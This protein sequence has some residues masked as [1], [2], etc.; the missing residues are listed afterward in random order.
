MKRLSIIVAVL[1]LALVASVLTLPQTSNAQAEQQV[2]ELE[3]LI[4]IPE[5]INRLCRV[6]IERSEEPSPEGELYLEF[7]SGGFRQYVTLSLTQGLFG[8]FVAI[9]R[10]D[11]IQEQWQ[12]NVLEQDEIDRWV[13]SANGNG[14]ARDVWHKRLLEDKEAVLK[15]EFLPTDEDSTKAIVDEIVARFLPAPFVAAPIPISLN[16]KCGT[17]CGANSQLA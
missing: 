8:G 1:V 16:Y 5:D 12:V 6:A 3:F 7:E 17:G 14:T 4:V 10:I 2:R 13:I 15:E 11:F 9:K